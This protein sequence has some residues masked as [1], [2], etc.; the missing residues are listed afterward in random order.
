MLEDI[1]HIIDALAQAKVMGNLAPAFYFRW[2][3][4]EGIALVAEEQQQKA[5]SER[6][7]KIAGFLIAEKND[8]IAYAQLIYLFVHPLSRK[9][10]TGSALMEHF[11]ETC[12]KQGVKY[13]DLHAQ[14]DAARFYR[15][16][17]F[18]P[19]GEFVTMYK[20]I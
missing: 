5:E 2:V 8:K 12:R 17:G 4:E 7:K 3:I 13:I 20:E 19:E 14:Q 10:G 11:L 15:K 16:L 18:L 9:K 1:P 6:S